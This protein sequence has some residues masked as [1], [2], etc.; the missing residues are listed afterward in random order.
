MATPSSKRPDQRYE[1]LAAEILRRFNASAKVVP[2]LK[3]RGRSGRLRQ[4]DIAVHSTVAGQPIFLAFECKHYTRP[5]ALKQ[6]EE[7]I[8]KVEDVRAQVGILISDSGFDDGALARA[9]EHGRIQL[10]QLL[11]SSQG[12]LRTKL[13]T[14]LVVS[15]TSLVWPYKVAFS[16]LDAA[17]GEVRPLNL[18]E[19]EQRS[20]LVSHLTRNGKS[21]VEGFHRWS[22]ENAA[23]LNDGPHECVVKHWQEGVDGVQWTFQF[24]KVT[25]TFARDDV[26]VGAAGLFDTLNG[27]LSVGEA[28]SFTLEE[29]E[30]RAT[31]QPRPPDY[32]QEGVNHYRR[33]ASYDVGAAEEVARRLATDAGAA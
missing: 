5:V 11:D 7:L 25:E 16:R 31:W 20:L 33:V 8:G 32:R 23:N 10:C 24:T 18:Q 12:W 19:P 21:I 30:I 9:K 29:S 14:Q 22:N 26:I 15:F 27:S 1:A 6:V 4:I 2:N 13:S 28:G 17:S 3:V